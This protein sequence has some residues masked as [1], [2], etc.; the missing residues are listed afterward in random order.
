MSIKRVAGVLDILEHSSMGRVV[1]QFGGRMLARLAGGGH[2]VRGN[3]NGIYNGER[4]QT[5]ACNY[6]MIIYRCVKGEHRIQIGFP[7]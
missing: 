4:L 6:Y 3:H 2:S 5:H 1:I 7:L